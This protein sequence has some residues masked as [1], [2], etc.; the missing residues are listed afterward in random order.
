MQNLWQFIKYGLVGVC[1]TLAHYTWLFSLSTLYANINPAYFAFSGAFLGAV[2]NYTLNY[3][4]TFLSAKKHAMAFP[5]F[6]TLAGLNM[7]V[8]SFVV[9]FAVNTGINY[10]AGQLLATAMCVPLGFI[11][12]KKVVFNEKRY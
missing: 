5:Q 8:S 11:I 6:V 3:R 1:G 10:M 2:V 7:L 9:Q 4:Y 12:S